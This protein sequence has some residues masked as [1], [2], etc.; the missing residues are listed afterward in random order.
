MPYTMG[1]LGIAEVEALERLPRE[2][3]ALLAAESSDPSFVAEFLV[4]ALRT[5]DPYETIMARIVREAAGKELADMGL[6]DHG[7][8]KSFFKRAASAIKRVHKAVEKKIVPKAIQKLHAKIQKPM[9]KVWRKYGNIIIQIAGVVLAP[10]T[11]GASLAAAAVLVA[12]NSAY[13]AKRAA[14]Q[15]KKAAKA[16]AGAMEAD[17]NR[18]TA[19]LA[20]QVDRFYADNQA[21]FLEHGIGPDQWARLTL[22]QKIDIINA[23]AKGTLPVGIGPEVSGPGAAAPPGYAPPPGAPPGYG[24]PPGAPA[25]G[26]PGAPGEPGYGPP[27][28]APGEAPAGVFDIMVEGKKL[29]TAANLDDAVEAALGATI[30]GDRFEILANGQSMGLRVRTSDGAI[31][32]PADIEAQVRAMP[33]AKMGE[34]VAQAEAEMA[35][36]AGGGFPW[37]LLLVGGGA[38]KVTGVI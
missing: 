8:G 13:N 9:K 37:W 33:R 26:A 16:E 22:D 24:P 3:Q 21:W 25:P 31:E 7:L 36:A 20:A 30:S 15:A 4:P 23:G 27:P 2:L 12:A 11:G 35:A 29:G 6:A 1:G 5:P 34:F 14:D 32:V 17:A 18:Q 28:A 19:E 10:F 38:L